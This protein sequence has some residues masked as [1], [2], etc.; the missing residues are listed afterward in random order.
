MLK[1]SIQ[2]LVLALTISA[3]QVLAVNWV[4]CNDVSKTV[5]MMT[6]VAT[7]LPVNVLQKM[8]TVISYE[9]GRVSDRMLYRVQSHYA[10]GDMWAGTMELTI[11][12]QT[13]RV[14]RM[15]ENY[16]TVTHKD[17][18]HVRDQMGTEPYEH[19]TEEEMTVKDARRMAEVMLQVSG[20]LDMPTRDR[21][22]NIAS[23]TARMEGN[24]T[25]FHIA[26]HY[27]AG[28]FWRGTLE[29]DITETPRRV[30]RR[31]INTYK[32]IAKDLG[33]E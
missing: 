24:A 10:D 16:Y 7:Q 21:V 33:A 15:V 9:V 22:K 1:K 18:G 17:L 5:E 11:V 19:Y 28:D 12:E 25:V 30:G 23:V 8:E 31:L 20:M 32:V 6:Q 3:H 27:P 4:P 29:L 2:L 14:G 13:R 26:A